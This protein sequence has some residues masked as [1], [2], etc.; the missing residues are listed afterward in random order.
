M[1]L[2]KILLFYDFVNEELYKVLTDRS[3][4]GKTRITDT[5]LDDPSSAKSTGSGILLRKQLSDIEMLDI[6]KSTESPDTRK[7]DRLSVVINNLEFLKYKEAT[8]GELYCEYCKKGPLKIYEFDYSRITNP[9]N[10]KQY[11]NI[12]FNNKF[13]KKDG[14]TADH[15]D[16][17][18]KG[19]DLFDY[20]NFI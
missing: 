18:S 12:R 13:N 5:I 19:G 17:I 4:S 1:A 7:N 3:G 8:I 9:I 2:K 16:P 14:A 20:A 6:I 11:R 10:K 15:K